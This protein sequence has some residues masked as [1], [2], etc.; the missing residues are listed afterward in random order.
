MRLLA[1]DMANAAAWT[2]LI[3]LIA[4]AFVMVVI[5]GPFGLNLAA[6]RAS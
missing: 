4:I 5:L 1:T 3:G 2:V 6:C